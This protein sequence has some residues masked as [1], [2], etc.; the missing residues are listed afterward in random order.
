MSADKHV[1]IHLPHRNSKPDSQRIDVAL[2]RLSLAA[3]LIDAAGRGLAPFVMANTT[4]T[5]LQLSIKV[6]CFELELA[7]RFPHVPSCNNY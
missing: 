7:E 3:R 5:L 4:E 2:A 1:V 6:D